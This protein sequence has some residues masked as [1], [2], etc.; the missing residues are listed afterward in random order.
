MGFEVAYDPGQNIKIA[1]SIEKYPVI[2]DTRKYPPVEYKSE[3]D[4]AWAEV[5]KELGVSGKLSLLIS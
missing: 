5:A 2:Y 3:A 4:C 1:N